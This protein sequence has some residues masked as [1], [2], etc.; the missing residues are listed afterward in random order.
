MAVASDPH[1][2]AGFPEGHQQVEGAAAG[3]GVAASRRPPRTRLQ[4]SLLNRRTMSGARVRRRVEAVHEPR[5]R[6]HWRGDSKG[7]VLGELERFEVVEDER[8]VHAP[9]ELE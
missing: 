2:P 9:A 6:P 5:L 3:A 4:S 1:A 7:I 8:L